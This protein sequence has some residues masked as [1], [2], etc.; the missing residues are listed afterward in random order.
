M[1]TSGS[2]FTLPATTKKSFAAW[3]SMIACKLQ[4][5]ELRSI[6]GVELGWSN[7]MVGQINSLADWIRFFHTRFGW[8]SFQDII[9]LAEV[10]GRH[11]HGLSSAVVVKWRLP[12]QQYVAQSSACALF[13]SRITLLIQL[14]TM[15][16]IMITLKQNRRQLPHTATDPRS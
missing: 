12:C 13:L 5:I 6:D 8:T 7:W 3:S 15:S 1:A 16:S 2:A 11:N 4:F 14:D 10:L 9:M